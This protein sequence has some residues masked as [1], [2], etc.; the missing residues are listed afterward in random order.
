MLL[1]IVFFG[2]TDEAGKKKNYKTS[3]SGHVARLGPL[4]NVSVLPPVLTSYGGLYL[5]RI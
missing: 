4:G 3:G 5:A 1:L 2:R